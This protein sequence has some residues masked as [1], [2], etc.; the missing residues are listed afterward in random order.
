MRIFGKGQKLSKLMKMNLFDTADFAVILFDKDY[1]IIEANPTARTIFSRTLKGKERREREKEIA[2]GIRQYIKSGV[3]EAEFEYGEK[4]YRCM[5]EKFMYHGK[6]CGYILSIIDNNEQKQEVLNLE[7]ESQQKSKFLANM[8]HDLRSPLHAIIGAS[9]VL[10]AKNNM[11]ATNRNYVNM[12]RSSSKVLLG[13]VNEILLH[14]K[15][16]AGKVVLSNKP[17]SFE[18]MVKELCQI[19]IIGLKNKD[20]EFYLDFDSSY[21]GEVIGDAM[22]V[23]EVIQNMLSNAMKFTEQGSIRCKIICE[24]ELEKQ[25]V[26]FTCEVIDTGTGMS[27][28][29]LKAIFDEY[30]SFA[31]QKKKEGTGL[32]MSI[33]RQLA[34]LMGGTVRAESDGESGS[35]VWVTFYQGVE[36]D[37]WCQP[38]HYAQQD[39]QVRVNKSAAIDAPSVQ[40]MDANVLVVDD[41]EANR[42]LFAQMTE[43]WKIHPDAAASGAEAIEMVKQKKYHLVFMDLMMP[44]MDGIEA[45]EKIREF[46][47]VPVILLTADASDETKKK[48]IAAGFADYMQKPINTKQLES[49]FEKFIPKEY[50]VAVEKN[51]ADSQ[52]MQTEQNL[53]AYRMILETIETELEQLYEMLP[54][55]LKMDLS[56]FRIKVHGIKGFTRQI[57]KLEISRQAEIM[58]MAAKTE[59]YRFIEENLDEFLDEMKAT[60]EE[61]RDELLTLPKPKV[62]VSDDSKE[63][64]FS[65]L[66]EAFDEFDLKNVKQ[67]IEQLKN[68]ELDEEEQELVAQLEEACED[69]DYEVG[70][71]I[72]ETRLNS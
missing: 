70:S 13:M 72:L 43:R 62:E 12:I 37:I 25:R 46:S 55:Y 51:T 63:E 5:I 8:S 2:D 27:K 44:E 31:S 38:V 50:R 54:K 16:E 4:Y 20:V 53:L 24:P 23:R 15:L 30:A 36:K 39:L 49:N 57:Q 48:S 26:K 42:Q 69:I 7:Q 10:M 1:Q 60:L 68:R 32:G 45:T 29:Q 11:S 14:S 47:D 64:L 61:I 19:M 17:Y 35:R 65:R 33:V 18:T 40:F 71:S 66:K 9:D 22:R 3:T 59:N 28:E 58:E 56:M 6:V 21:P 67:C 52:G 34:E 41:I